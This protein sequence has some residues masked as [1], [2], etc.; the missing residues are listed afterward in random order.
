MWIK[1]W[2]WTEVKRNLSQQCVFAV[3]EVRCQISILWLCTAR[4]LLSLILP[5]LSLIPLHQ[6]EHR[7]ESCKSAKE[8]RNLSL[9]SNRWA[10]VVG[11][12]PLE[13]LQFLQGVLHHSL[14][15]LLWRKLLFNPSDS[16]LNPRVNKQCV[17]FKGQILN[18]NVKGLLNNEYKKPLSHIKDKNTCFC[19]KDKC[20]HQLVFTLLFCSLQ[21]CFL[22]LLK[23][24]YKL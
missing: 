13:P 22:S 1:C 18:L 10:S 17:T 5:R 21:L 23:L 19:Q 6:W 3:R 4:C 11:W 20:V 9:K 24:D 8:R 7:S 16:S 15:K 14:V 2:P 12:K